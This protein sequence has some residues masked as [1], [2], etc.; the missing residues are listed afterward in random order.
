[1]HTEQPLTL[2][3]QQ[4]YE[5]VSDADVTATTTFLSGPEPPLAPLQQYRADIAQAA[6]DLT[7][8]KAAAAGT[9]RSPRRFRPSPP[10]CRPTPATSPRRRPSTRSATR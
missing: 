10:G 9:S 7:T 3:A 4:M 6:A 2:A 8:L 1:V 5:S